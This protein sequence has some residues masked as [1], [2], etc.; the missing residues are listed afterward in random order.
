M[1]GVTMAT[2]PKETNEEQM[3][4]ATVNSNYIIY[5]LTFSSAL[6]TQASKYT[7]YHDSVMPAAGT[8]E[9]T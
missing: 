8:T 5:F 7:L 6:Q 2:N 1:V 3:N 4:L 9:H